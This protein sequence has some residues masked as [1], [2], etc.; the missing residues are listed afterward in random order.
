M[1]AQDIAVVEGHGDLARIYEAIGQAM[2]AGRKVRFTVEEGL[3]IAVGG[4]AWTLPF[5]RAG[6]EVGQ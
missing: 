2:Y 4:E 5:G 3:K 6:D 1:R